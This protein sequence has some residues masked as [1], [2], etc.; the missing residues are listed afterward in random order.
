MW[1]KR[2]RLGTFFCSSALVFY[3]VFGMLPIGGG[4]LTTLENRFS[5]P[6]QMPKQVDGLVVLGGFLNV[7]ITDARQDYSF[8]GNIER[9]TSLLHLSKQYKGSPVLFTGGAGL[10]GHPE[11][12]E[13]QMLKSFLP[14]VVSADTQLIFENASR[15][16]FENALFSKE[17]IEKKGGGKWL[18]I[19]S[20]R[21]MPRAVGAFRKQNIDVIPY[22]VDYIT[23][24]E[25][26]NEVSFFPRNG[27]GTFGVAL[28]EWLGLLAYYL[29]DKTSEL[30][31]AP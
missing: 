11:L 8:N 28:H 20:A 19:T 31:P 5:K 12:N 15:N 6:V 13:A 2:V 29:T 4:L 30:F 1:A 24:G 9:A 18:L 10:I 14:D 22:P 27:L 3:I 26:S 17:L 7:F 16:T 21:H 23:S 25:L